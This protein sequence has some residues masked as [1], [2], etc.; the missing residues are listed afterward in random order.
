MA[1]FRRG[2]ATYSHLEKVLK[3]DRLDD[4]QILAEI[5]YF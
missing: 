5:N 3:I 2:K 1:N 4:P